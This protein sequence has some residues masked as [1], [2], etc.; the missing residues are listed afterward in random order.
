MILC[1][2][3]AGRAGLVVMLRMTER[4]RERADPARR[5]GYRVSAEETRTSISFPR[6]TSDRGV[7]CP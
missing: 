2:P 6:P 4:G 5:A 1:R 3:Y 7:L